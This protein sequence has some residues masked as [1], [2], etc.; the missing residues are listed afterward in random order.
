MT[1]N[2]IKIIINQ[3]TTNY[4]VKR[5]SNLTEFSQFFFKKRCVIGFQYYYIINIAIYNAIIIS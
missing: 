1:Y 5:F 3:N 4:E 2:Y